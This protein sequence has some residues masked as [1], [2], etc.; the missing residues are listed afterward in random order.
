MTSGITEIA[1]ELRMRT[2]PELARA[3]DDWFGPLHRAAAPPEAG[4]YRRL[5]TPDSPTP[6][7]TPRTVPPEIQ[8]ST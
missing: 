7:R 3:V 2:D 5:A 6:S 1:F 4:I 8:E